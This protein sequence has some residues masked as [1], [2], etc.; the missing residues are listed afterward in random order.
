MSR[1]EIHFDENNITH[2][3][4]DHEWV[5][6]IMSSLEAASNRGKSIARVDCKFASSNIL[7]KDFNYLK[8]LITTARK[9]E[10]VE[11]EAAGVSF[12]AHEHHVPFFSIRGISDIVGYKRKGNFNDYAAKI[13][14][15]FTRAYLE[16]GPFQE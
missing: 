13:A 11:M 9:V 15:S 6:K 5:K 14:A 7:M 3:V 1:P 12:A 10:V 4:N 2:G 16:M 8:N